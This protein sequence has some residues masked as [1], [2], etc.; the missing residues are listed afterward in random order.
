MKPE[1]VFEVEILDRTS[2][3]MGIHKLKLNPIRFSLWIV[4]LRRHEFVASH[5]HRNHFYE[6]GGSCMSDGGNLN[7]L[8]VEFSQD[9]QAIWIL[10]TAVLPLRSSFS[11]SKD[12]LSPSLRP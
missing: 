7:Q 8:I 2:S 12:T 6:M 10:A 11:V 4:D 3:L 5:P 1:R 9:S